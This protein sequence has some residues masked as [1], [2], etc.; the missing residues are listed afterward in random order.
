MDPKSYKIGILFGVL[1][2]ITSNHLILFLIG[3]PILFQN[4]LLSEVIIIGGSIG[5]IFVLSGISFIVL[6]KRKILMIP[7]NFVARVFKSKH[8]RFFVEGDVEI[9]HMGL[10]ESIS[11]A[12]YGSLL[13]LG[14]TLILLLGDVVN[15]AHAGSD[16]TLH[17]LAISQLIYHSQILVVVET[18]LLP[19]ILSV[20]FFAPWI[21]KEAGLSF[22]SESGETLRSVFNIG[23]WFEGFLKGFAGLNVINLL[24]ILLLVFQ[25]VGPIWLLL[26]IIIA[27]GSLFSIVFINTLIYV[28]VFRRKSVHIFRSWLIDTLNLPVLEVHTVSDIREYVPKDES[29]ESGITENQWDD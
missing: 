25:F 16:S 4:L 17:T 2:F 27:F 10:K 1:L 8:G 29:I 9:P 24:A 23:I 11:R 26:I 13:F 3:T 22:I 28:K 6:K 19:F 15:V 5:I 12:M 14:I 20:A 7:Y 21:S 18:I